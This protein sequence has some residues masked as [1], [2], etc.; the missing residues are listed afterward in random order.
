MLL[1]SGG[2]RTTSPGFA[3]ILRKNTWSDSDHRRRHADSF[4]PAGAADQAGTGQVHAGRLVVVHAL[5]FHP[6]ATAIVARIG[7]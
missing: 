3:V 6:A 5:R 7:Q 2:R 1:P 4:D